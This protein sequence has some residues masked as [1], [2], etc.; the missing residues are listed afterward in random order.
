MIY[1]L[2][3]LVNEKVYK[4][5]STNTYNYIH[6]KYVNINVFSTTNEMAFFKNVSSNHLFL[7]IQTNTNRYGISLFIYVSLYNVRKS[8]L[9][10]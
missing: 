9:L 1:S 4:P 10:I 6:L 5:L 3:T 7:K 2:H 8:E